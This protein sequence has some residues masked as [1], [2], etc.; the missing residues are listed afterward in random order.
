MSTT[1]AA[2]LPEKPHRAHHYWPP[3]RKKVKIKKNKQTNKEQTTDA[4]KNKYHAGF[5][6]I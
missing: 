4:T 6:K 3:C 5:C 1:R 2:R